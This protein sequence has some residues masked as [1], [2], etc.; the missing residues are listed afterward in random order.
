M[1]KSKH[2]SAD[3]ITLFDEI[4]GDPLAGS[5]FEAEEPESDFIESSQPERRTRTPERSEW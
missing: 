3:V 1:Q 5:G 4:G 2:V